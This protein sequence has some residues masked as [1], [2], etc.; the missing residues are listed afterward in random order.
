MLIDGIKVYYIALPLIYPWKTAY[1]DDNEIHTVLIKITS[2][3]HAGWGEACPLRTPTYSSEYANGVYDLITYL[4]APMLIGKEISSPKELLEIFSSYK[5]NYFAKAGIESAWWTLE[6]AIKGIPLHKLLGGEF[7]PVDCGADIGIQ[8]SIDTL[9][10]K[11][12]VVVQKGYKRLKLKVR[13]G[14]DLE[15]LKT[16]RNTFPNLPLQ[17]DCN[18]GYE[19]NDMDFFREIDK[20][21]L[22]MIEQPLFYSDFHGHSILQQQ[23][24]TPICLDESIRSLRDLRTAIQLNSCKIINIKYGR[25]GGLLNAL[26]LQSMAHD[27][28][29]SCWVGSML[30][31]AIGMGINIELATLPG[32]NY[33]NDLFESKYHFD[34]DLSETILEQNPDRTYFPSSHGGTPYP[35]CTEMLAKY[36]QKSKFFG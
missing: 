30:E 16:V 1:G 9:L 24:S 6:S 36:T 29:I 12:Q 17:I 34:E 19:L 32:F 27:A 31:S 5:G 26:K 18:G 21:N 33:P 8:N 25:V 3:E 14:W 10:N 15:I 11:I 20:L 35:P 2:G 13:K 7:R 22:A 23:I 4:F 28:G